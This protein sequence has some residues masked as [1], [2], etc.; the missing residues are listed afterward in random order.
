MTRRETYVN[1]HPLFC[2]H[3]TERQEDFGG[4]REVC[5]FDGKGERNT[6]RQVVI[7]CYMTETIINEH[8]QCVLKDFIQFFF[9]FESRQ[10]NWFSKHDPTNMATDELKRTALML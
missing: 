4:A 7:A 8:L 9:Y 3:T 6:P 2:A 1:L 10:M 5:T